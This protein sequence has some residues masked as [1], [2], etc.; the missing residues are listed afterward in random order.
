MN[1]TTNYSPCLRIIW[2]NTCLYVVSNKQTA[3]NSWRPKWPLATSAQNAECIQFQKCEPDAFQHTENVTHSN[4][5][6]S[7]V[8]AL[9]MVLLKSFSSII[10]TTRKGNFW[11]FGTSLWISVHGIW[12]WEQS[13]KNQTY[14][15]NEGNS[16]RTRNDDCCCPLSTANWPSG[17]RHLHL[18]R[19]RTPT[20]VFNSL[21]TIQ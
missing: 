11:A 14:S 9:R 2:I 3:V 16:S 18:I 21:S 7:H 15:S 8:H 19:Q 17:L 1:K 13:K 10:P 4:L 6:Y 20:L 5:L 12:N